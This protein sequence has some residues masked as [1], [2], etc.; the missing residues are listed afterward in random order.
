M[1]TFQSIVMLSDLTFTIKVRLFFD[2]SN[3]TNVSCSHHFINLTTCR[4]CSSFFWYS[5]NAII[6]RL[7]FKGMVWHSKMEME[8]SLPKT[9]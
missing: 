5:K 9:I 4:V 8:G 6:E 1:L 2:L 7:N 3:F